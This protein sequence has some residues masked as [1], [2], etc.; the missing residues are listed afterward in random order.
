MY[1]RMAGRLPCETERRSAFDLSGSLNRVE[2]TMRLLSFVVVALVLTVAAGASAG[3]ATKDEMK[4]LEGTWVVVSV[5]EAGKARPDEINIKGTELTF[6]GSNITVKL[7]K[8]EE[9]K[10]DKRT[11]RIDPAKKPKTIDI[12]PD[13]INPTRGIYELDGDTLRLGLGE[14]FGNVR[15][16]AFTDEKATILTLK[17]KK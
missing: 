17:R 6:A 15:P 11:Y 8:G 1:L 14:G 2:V 7:K 16:T 3:D 4:K 9:Q 13:D 10:I 5:S 12:R